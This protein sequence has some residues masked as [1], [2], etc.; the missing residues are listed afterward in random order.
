MIFFDNETEVQEYRPHQASTG[1]GQDS[2]HSTSFRPGS[3]RG[4]GAQGQS[5]DPIERRSTA[6]TMSDMGPISR[7][8]SGGALASSWGE[9]KSALSRGGMGGARDTE[10]AWR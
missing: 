9:P 3:F 2:S 1:G 7:R 8:G 5:S 10:R 6:P 4:G